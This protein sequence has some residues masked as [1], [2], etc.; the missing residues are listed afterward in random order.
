[1]EVGPT[2]LRR[3]IDQARKECQ[4]DQ[5]ATGAK[6]ISD[7]QQEPQELRAKVKCLYT[8][9]EILKGY[10]SLE[11]GSL[12]FFLV[13]GLRE[14]GVHPTSLLCSALSLPQRVL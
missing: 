1:M 12:S 7:G 5:P 13:E 11:V 14:S 9:A 8:T 10:G 4:K 3:W 2:K 6:A